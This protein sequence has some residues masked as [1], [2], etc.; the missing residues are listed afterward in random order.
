MAAGWPTGA[1][2]RLQRWVK[3]KLRPLLLGTPPGAPDWHEA[4]ALVGEC[5]R[6][7]QIVTVDEFP[8][9][10]SLYETNAGEWRT[11]YQ[12]ENGASVH[13]SSLGNKEVAKLVAA[14]IGEL[15]SSLDQRI[16]INRLVTSPGIVARRSQLRADRNHATKSSMVA[17]KGGGEPG[18]AEMPM[19]LINAIG[20]RAQIRHVRIAP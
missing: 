15:N 11:Y 16:E 12:V 20:A 9:L 1:L 18:H 8:T 10:R 2:Y 14:A 19:G 13:K 5:A 17:E 6:D 7:L 4:S 3:N